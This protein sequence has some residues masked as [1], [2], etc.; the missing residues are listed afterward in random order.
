VVT[1]PDVPTRPKRGA[2]LAGTSHAE[3]SDAKKPRVGR[4]PKKE[5]GKNREKIA[6]ALCQSTKDYSLAHKWAGCL[7]CE[8]WAHTYCLAKTSNAFQKDFKRICALRDEN[9]AL[10]EIERISLICYKCNEDLP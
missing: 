6:C 7:S 3:T 9:K 1:R 2:D 8:D 10:E 4:K 5:R